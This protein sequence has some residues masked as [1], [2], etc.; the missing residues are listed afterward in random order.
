M[1]KLNTTVL[2]R[3]DSPDI[4]YYCTDQNNI[5]AVAN[6]ATAQRFDREE[7]A[8]RSSF[9]AKMAPPTTIPCVE[10]HAYKVVNEPQARMA[11]PTS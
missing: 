9:G 4:V 3:L 6:T 5:S 1:N 8:Y 11:L 2:Q 7:A 10:H